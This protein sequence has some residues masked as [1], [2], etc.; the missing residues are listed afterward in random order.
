[1]KHPVAYLKS[2]KIYRRSLSV[3]SFPNDSKY[4]AGILK[5]KYL[6]SNYSE[7]SVLIFCMNTLIQGRSTSPAN[8]FLRK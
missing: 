6:N 8:I 1:M 5:L 7:N 2:C 3:K 4:A